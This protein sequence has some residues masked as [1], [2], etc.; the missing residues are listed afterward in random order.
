MPLKASN[1]VLIAERGGSGSAGSLAVF[2]PPHTFF[3]AREIATNLG[4][5]WYRKDAARHVRLRRASGRARRDA[6]VRGQLRA[7]QRA[8]RHVAAHAGVPLRQR[9]CRAAD[10]RCGAGVHAR[11]SLQGA[12]RL[13]GDEPSLPHGSR[14]APARRRQ[15]RRRD[16]RSSGAQ[17]ARHHHRQ[18]DRFDRRRR[19]PWRRAHRSAGGDAGVGRRRAAALGRRLRRDAEP[20]VLR[21]PARRA[22]RPAVLAPGLLDAGPRRR[23][24]AGRERSGRTAASTTS[25]APTI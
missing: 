6:A 13:P 9:G 3:W 20:G 17:G 18:P 24:A 12:A 22:H 25:A 10:A 23:P 1:R 16:S 11:R 7:L 8:A 21:Q 19:R 4:Y 2:P 5:V 15:P 14:T